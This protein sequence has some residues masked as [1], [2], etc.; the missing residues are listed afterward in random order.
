MIVDELGEK[1]IELQDLWSSVCVWGRG[2]RFDSWCILF[3]A[4]YLIALL[5]HRHDTIPIK[6]AQKLHACIDNIIYICPWISKD[7]Q[8][9]IRLF[10][11]D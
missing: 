1:D 7:V 10:L 6:Q 3:A 9:E 8:V 4:E 11:D 5:C 2:Q